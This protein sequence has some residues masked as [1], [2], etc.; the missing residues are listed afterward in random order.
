[1]II[2]NDTTNDTK[3]QQTLDC[4]TQELKQLD[5]TVNAAKSSAIRIQTKRSSPT[6]QQQSPTIFTIKKETIPYEKK[7]RLLG[8]YINEKLQLD[9]SANETITNE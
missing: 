3:L 1:M 8:V 9:D 2:S 5:L 4:I 7:M 6:N